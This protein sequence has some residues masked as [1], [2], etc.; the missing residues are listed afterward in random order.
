LKNDKYVH[1]FVISSL[2]ELLDEN[3]N[4]FLQS[5]ESINLGEGIRVIDFGRTFTKWPLY[6]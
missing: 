4:D 5:D 6:F 1:N 3:A 2:V